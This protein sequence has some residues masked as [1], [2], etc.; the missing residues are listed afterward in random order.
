MTSQ[1][2]SGLIISDQKEE[3][4]GAWSSWV[5]I[6]GDAHLGR[7]TSAMFGV[8]RASEGLPGFLHK[9]VGGSTCFTG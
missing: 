2:S 3:E 5:I 6:S 8:V 7:C 9:A 4:I 1:W